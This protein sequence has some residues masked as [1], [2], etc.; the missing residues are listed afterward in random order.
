MAREFEGQGLPIDPNGVQE[1][2]DILG[3]G[4][5]ELWAVIRVETSGCGFLPDRRPKILFERHVFSAKTRHRYDAKYPDISN[6][7]PGGYGAGG[8]AQYDRLMRAAALDR[9]A[10]L[11]STSWGIGQVMGYN[12]GIAGYR[13][14][15]DM[16]EDMCATENAQIRAMARFIKANRLDGALRTH[17]WP[18]F[19]AGY[20][21]PNFRINNYD[22]RLAAACEYLARGGLPDI[23]VR[24]AQV[25]LT[26]LGYDPQ[27]IDGA[28]GRLTRAAMNDF[29]EQNRLPVTMFVD[30]PTFA[31]LA[32]AATRQRAAPKARA[33]K[34]APPKARH[35]VR[36]KVRKVKR[37][38]TRKVKRAKRARGSRAKRR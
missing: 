11:L 25:Y 16:V 29:Q 19:A 36:R 18:R 31:A 14:V 23:T 12:A 33:P 13:R 27:G 34:A 6:P 37:K 4:A 5:A 1:A 10:A 9:H 20:N 21:G 8:A 35:K 24:A 30:E 38:V 32:K 22:T 2:V 26:Y 28:M 15:E 3:S 7:R 17:D